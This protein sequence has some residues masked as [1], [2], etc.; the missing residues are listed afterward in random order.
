VAGEVGPAAL[1]IISTE[2]IFISSPVLPTA[3]QLLVTFASAV[4]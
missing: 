2:I 4:R 1:P 3:G